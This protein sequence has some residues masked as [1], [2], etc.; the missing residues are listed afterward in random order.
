MPVETRYIRFTNP[1]LNS[2]IVDYFAR[3]PDS[4]YTEILKVST[5]KELENPV[6]VLAYR[7]DTGEKATE[8]ISISLVG[9]ALMLHCRIHDIR[10]PKGAKKSV[11]VQEG[12]VVLKVIFVSGQAAANSQQSSLG[13]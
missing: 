2:A 9:A 4:P 1:E 7:K 8:T 3:K 6:A 5:T 12:N 13:N 10:L 11:E